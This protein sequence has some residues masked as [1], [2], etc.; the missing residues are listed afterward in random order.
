MFEL[1]E[2]TFVSDYS[3]PEVIKH[4]RLYDFVPRDSDTLFVSIGDSWTYG[5][6]LDDEGDRVSLTYGHYVSEILNADFLN[7]AVPATS[8]CWMLKKY[9]QLC[10]IAD[11]LP[12]KEIKVFITLTEYGREIL[13][14]DDWDEQL[15]ANYKTAE[16]AK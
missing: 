6:R 1:L 11:K 5:Y 16:T 2:Q 14:D 9:Q 12:Y 3:L 10:S 15:N 7:L 4:K 13:T 8:N